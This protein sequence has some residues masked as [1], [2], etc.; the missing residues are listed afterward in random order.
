MHAA[1][2][3]S[4]I[5]LDVE[6]LQQLAT[7]YKLDFFVAEAVVA[8]NYIRAVMKKNTE[9]KLTME[10]VYRLLDES[11]FPTLKK[12]FQVALTVHASNKLQVRDIV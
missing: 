11:A 6:P 9:D 10:K 5:F 12:L 4:D 8:R 7:H 1:L 3:T 2:P